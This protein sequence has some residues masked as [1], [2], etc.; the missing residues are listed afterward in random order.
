M[1]IVVASVIS[2]DTFT[3]YSL[4]DLRGHPDCIERVGRWCQEQYCEKISL[5]RPGNR[6]RAAARTFKNGNI[7]RYNLHDNGLCSPWTCWNLSIY[8]FC[9]LIASRILQIDTSHLSG[10]MGFDARTS[11][12]MNHT[13]TRVI[14][15]LQP[16]EPLYS[17]PPICRWYNKILKKEKVD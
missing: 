6:H 15:Q 5:T 7:A 3:I 11:H 4:C 9:L 8:N 12:W 17:F 14:W 13:V 16:L 1:D 10:A 2:V